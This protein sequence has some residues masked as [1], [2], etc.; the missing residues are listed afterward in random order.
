MISELQQ[1]ATKWHTQRFPDAIIYEVTTKTAEELGE[2]AAEVL[3]DFSSHMNLKEKPVDTNAPAEAADV[4][5]ALM[6]L[7]GRWYPGYDL[8]EE[9]AKKLDKLTDPNSGHRAAI[10][11]TI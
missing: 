7:L 3:I 8:I 2:C 5:L 1:L 6:V 9:V 11:V 10:K 4:V